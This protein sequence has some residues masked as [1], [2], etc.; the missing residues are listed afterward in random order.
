MNVCGGK[1]SKG[2]CKCQ[3]YVYGRTEGAWDICYV[4]GCGHTAQNH[5]D[6]AAK[7][8]DAKDKGIPLKSEPKPVKS[9]KVIYSG[10]QTDTAKGETSDI[11]TSEMRAALKR[12]GEKV[13]ERGRLDPKQKAKAKELIAAGK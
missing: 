10:P 6:Q 4:E 12:N 2:A 13:G 7:I 1:S 8:K 3:G 5:T 11:P 9:E